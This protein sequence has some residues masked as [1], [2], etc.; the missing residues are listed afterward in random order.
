M[1]DATLETVRWR[2]GAVRILD[3]TRLPREEVYAELE[4]VEGVIEAVRTLA[5]RGAPAIGVAGALG[6][7]GAGAGF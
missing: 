2:H 6:V 4:T 5:V 1:N 3:Q 7:A